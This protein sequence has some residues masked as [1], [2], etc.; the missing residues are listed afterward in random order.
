MLTHTNPS[1]YKNT[2]AGLK[3]S[4]IAFAD[5]EAVALATEISYLEIVKSDS[6]SKK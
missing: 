6:T 4:E 2:G 5:N 1:L 3:S